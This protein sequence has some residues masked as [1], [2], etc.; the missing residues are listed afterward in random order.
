MIGRNEGELK[1]KGRISGLCGD[2]GL[3]EERIEER[4]TLSTSSAAAAARRQGG[5]EG[6]AAQDGLEGE[7]GE[8]F[9]S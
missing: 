2:G 1:K 8:I 4:A 6:G 3:V 9:W 5:D 7:K